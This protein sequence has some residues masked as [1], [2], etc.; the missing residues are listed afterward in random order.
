MSVLPTSS[1]GRKLVMAATGQMMIIFIILHVA[2]NSTI[3]FGRLNAYAAGLHALPAL[4]WAVRLALLPVIVLH[5]FYAIALKLENN[6]ARPV[7]YLGRKNVESSFAGRNMVWSG[8][9]IGTFLVYHLLHFTFQVI[10][11]AT[12]A[13][14]HPDAAGRPDVFL[15]VARGLQQ[16]GN[17]VIYL[18]GVAALW[19]H[20]S[21]GIQS[22][23]QT[24]GLNGERSFPYIRR[25]G[26]AASIMLFLAYASIPA[27]IF[28]GLL[29]R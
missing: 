9:L 23:F 16:K 15:M 5:L 2:G 19:L 3:F 8:A 10:D 1:V 14:A 4:L 20:L 29:L 6:R 24:W 18:L 21:H 26:S 28:A 17:A 27:A 22:S 12:A 11:P 13:V 7:D 25:G